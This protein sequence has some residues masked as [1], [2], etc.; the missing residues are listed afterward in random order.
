MKGYD[1]MLDTNKLLINFY[2]VNQIKD[3]LQNLPLEEIKMFQQRCIDTYFE[4]DKER[5]LHE[6]NKVIKVKTAFDEYD[7]IESKY[8]K[9]CS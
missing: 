4:A 7:K 3:N 8:N 6:L 1:S 9:S 5:L 2:T